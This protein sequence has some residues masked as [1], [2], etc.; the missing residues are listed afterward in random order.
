MSKVSRPQ[1]QELTELHE[2][3][4]EQ[5]RNQEYMNALDKYA[6]HLEATI[7]QLSEALNGEHFNYGREKEMEEPHVNGDHADTCPVCALIAEHGGTQ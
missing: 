7:R 2:D 5:E 1:F 4:E 6:T 3:W